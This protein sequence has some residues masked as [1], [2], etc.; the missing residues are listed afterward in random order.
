MA[1]ADFVSVH[2]SHRFLFEIKPTHGERGAVCG[3]IAAVIRLVPDKYRLFDR[4]RTGGHILSFTPEFVYV[5]G[6]YTLY[7]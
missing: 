7:F 4:L 1:V 6:E 3:G 2:R 5:Q